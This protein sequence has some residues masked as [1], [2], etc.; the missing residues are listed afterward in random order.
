MRILLINPS[1]REAEV[2]HY[3]KVVEKSR[4]IYPPLG[5]MYI[6][7]ILKKAGHIVKL[8]DLDADHKSL[9]QINNVISK[10]NP[11]VVGFYAMTFTYHQVCKILNSIKKYHPNI[12]S[13]IGGPN[14]SAFPYLTLK[15][16]IF[17]YSVIGEGEI[18]TLELVEALKEK[19]N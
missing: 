17:D 4:G 7:S 19:N 10:F 13:I 9:R 11:T 16:S 8:M 5:L 12:I 15:H 6:A 14:S 1:L 2:N 18:I 3:S